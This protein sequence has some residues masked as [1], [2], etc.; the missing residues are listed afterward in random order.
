M[1]VQFVAA[2]VVIATGALLERTHLTAYFSCAF[3]LAAWVYPVFTHWTRS[4]DG[5][6]SPTLAAG[7]R[8]FGVGLIDFA[9]CAPVHIIG[10]LC[11]LAGA[12]VVGARL[13][14]FGAN[15]TVRT[16]HAH[17]RQQHVRIQQ[18]VSRGCILLHAYAHAHA[19]I[20]VTAFSPA[21]AYMVKFLSNKL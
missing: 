11:G 2:A 15:G 6:A 16:P 12:Y 8:L 3:L 21:S 13:E 18:K 17:A 4:A 5:W 1:V 7:E 10:G 14:R 9:G 20:F 19:F